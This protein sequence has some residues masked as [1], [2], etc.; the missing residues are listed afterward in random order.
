MSHVQVWLSCDRRRILPRGVEDHDAKA[1]GGFRPAGASLQN[2]MS[3]YGPDSST[4]EKASNAELKPVKVGEGNMAFM[5]EA[6]LSIGVTEW[7]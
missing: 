7:V 4:H 2:I 5:F 1:G 6:L 3:A